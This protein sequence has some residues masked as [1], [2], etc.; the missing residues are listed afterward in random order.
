[1]CLVGSVIRVWC[2]V[3]CRCM[4]RGALI[5]AWSLKTSL[6]TQTLRTTWWN[7]SSLSN[8]KSEDV[9]LHFDI[10]IVLCVCLFF[11]FVLRCVWCS[12]PLL[13]SQRWP[14]RAASGHGAARFRPRELGLRSIAKLWEPPGWTAALLCSQLRARRLVLR[15]RLVFPSFYPFLSLTCGFLTNPLGRCLGPFLSS[16]VQV[17]TSD[18]DGALRSAL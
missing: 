6:W 9:L 7:A 18:G 16:V 1:M 14:C 12:C 13:F 17:W 8:R 15:Y 10:F 3:L 11:L 2:C 4:R 5:S